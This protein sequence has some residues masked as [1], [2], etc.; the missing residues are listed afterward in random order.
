MAGARIPS[1]GPRGEGWVALQLI[2][3]A[4]VFGLGLIGSPWPLAGRPWLTVLAVPLI[5]VSALL[6][7]SGVRHLDGSLTALPMPREGAQLREGGPYGL[8]R[9]PLYGALILVAVAFPLLTSPWALPPAAALSLILLAKSSREEH[10]LAERYP[11]YA[12]Y[13]ARVRRRFFPFLW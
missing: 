8:V 9:H 12:A 13:R 1:L 4:L 11:A 6:F 3:L 10:W 2:G 7:I 5:G